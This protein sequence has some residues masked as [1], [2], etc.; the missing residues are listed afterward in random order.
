MVDKLSLDDFFDLL[1]RY[2]SD[3]TNWPLSSGQLDSVVAFLTR[4]F[5]A[6]EAVE[7]MRV[8]EG[9]LCLATPRAPAGLAD[10]F[11]AAAGILD[12]ATP[13]IAH[14]RSRRVVLN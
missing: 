3:V 2:G 5:A 1:G 6:R 14:S 4:S 9:E 13:I 11:L 8:L 12:G 10:R 7:E